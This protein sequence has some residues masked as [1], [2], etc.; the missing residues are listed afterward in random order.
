MTGPTTSSSSWDVFAEN[1]NSA[2]TKKPQTVIAT[3]LAA[4]S[5]T[6]LALYVSLNASAIIFSPELAAAW[7]C[8]KLTRKFRQPLNVALAAGLVHIVPSIANIKVSPLLTGFAPVDQKMTEKLQLERKKLET[9][10][11]AMKPIITN[12]SRGAIWLQGPIDRYGLA[13]YI[14]AKASSLMTIGAASVLIRNG[15]D[16]EHALASW[17]MSES[18]GGAVGTVA[19]SSVCNVFF[20]PVHFYAVI[21]GV[22]SIDDIACHVKSHMSDEWKQKIILEERE[23]R[24]NHNSNS[25]KKSSYTDDKNGR[26]TNHDENNDAETEFLKDRE[27]RIK[28]AF[29]IILMMWSLGVSLYAIRIMGKKLTTTNGTNDN[30]SESVK[31]ISTD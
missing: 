14:S 19:A 23:Y 2:L 9:N 30:A 15:I 22:R 1:W 16:V 24:Q 4:Q 8:A 31:P 5:T 12:I 17:G 20:T 11:P 6:W 28:E 18:L 10:V 29:S 27:D 21:Y 25:Q 3:F 7:M 26:K 13:F